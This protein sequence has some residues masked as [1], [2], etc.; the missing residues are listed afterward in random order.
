VHSKEGENFECWKEGMTDQKSIEAKVRTRGP[1][2]GCRLYN[3][4]S[5]WVKHA[6]ARRPQLVRKNKK[7]SPKKVSKLTP[8]VFRNLVEVPGSDDTNGQGLMLVGGEYKTGRKGL[9]NIQ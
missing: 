5:G 2:V 3:K 7:P 1:P 4:K 6:L 9:C 8:R